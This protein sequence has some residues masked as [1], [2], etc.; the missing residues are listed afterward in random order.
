[1][2]EERYIVPT[3]SL[4]QWLHAKDT[5]APLIAVGTTALRT[6][7]SLDNLQIT[8]AASHLTTA[9]RSAHGAVYTST[10]YTRTNLG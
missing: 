1:M 4:Q 10:R 3:A 2:H 9:I 5:S 7:E 6:I 8:I